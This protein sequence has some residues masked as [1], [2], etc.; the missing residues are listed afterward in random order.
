MTD[1]TGTV[2]LHQSETPCINQLSVRLCRHH[3]RVAEVQEELLIHTRSTALA[4]HWVV[5]SE[6]I[7]GRQQAQRHGWLCRRPDH[8]VE[9]KNTA[10][11]PNPVR[12]RQVGL[13]ICTLC[14]GRWLSQTRLTPVGLSSYLVYRGQTRMP[15]GKTK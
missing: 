14:K 4:H 12:C 7:L 6:G 10:S 5:R 9:V 11:A 2:R 15:S 3:G 13:D 8:V 1:C